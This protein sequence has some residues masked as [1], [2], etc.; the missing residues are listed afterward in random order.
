MTKN[1]GT[2]DRV[3][4]LSLG[5]ILL[6]IAFLVIT[7]LIIKIVIIAL[8]LFCFYEAL[9]SWCLFYQLIGKNTCPMG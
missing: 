7:H 2:F 4:R 9:A 6:G 3:M 5:V 8:A 1:I